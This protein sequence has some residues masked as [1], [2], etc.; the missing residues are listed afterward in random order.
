LSNDALPNYVLENYAKAVRMD[1]SDWVLKNPLPA[2]C[3]CKFDG[4]R[5]FLFKS[6][7]DLVISG[8]LGSVFTPKANPNAFAK[9]PEFTH[10]PN[11]MILDG[12]YVSNDGL[13]LFDVL[14]IDNRD[15]RT[16]VLEERKKILDEILKGTGLEV[17]VFRASSIPQIQ[18]L[19]EEFVRKGFEGLV[20]KNPL[21]K[22]GQANSWLKVKRFDTIDCFVIDFED[23]PEKARTGVARS[24]HI[25]VI[26]R[27]GQTV[28]IGKVG[29]FLEKVD[30]KIV[31]I[32][33]VL[34]VRFQQVTDDWKLR[35][36]FIRRVRHDKPT[37]ECNMSQLENAAGRK[38]EP[39]E[40]NY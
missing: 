12:E 39:K 9:I 34:E 11:R 2:I 18:E 8:K 17:E 29:S 31:R 38:Y 20:V 23:T 22:Y 26:D 13:H 4:I 6:G 32:G 5:V 40:N 30:P 15:V 19:K 7:P 35:A 14:R 33:S 27:K 1:L 16:L 24:W 36:P 37:S 21:S 28:D 3:E 10:A 25:G